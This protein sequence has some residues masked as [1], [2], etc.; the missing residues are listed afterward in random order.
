[1]SEKISDLAVEPTVPD[2]TNLTP[3]ETTEE[4][5]VQS[6]I[7][8]FTENKMYIYI[9][10]AV[11][12]LGVVLYY[13][14]IKNKKE[15]MAQTDKKPRLALPKSNN[16]G[17]GQPQTQTQTQPKASEVPGPFNPMGQE[18]YVLDNNGNPVKVSGN[19]PMVNQPLP[20]L[21]L[22]NQQ[23]SQ[24][25]IMMLQKQMMEKKMMEQQMMEQ[26][27][28]E[29]QMREAQ[30][31]AQAQAQAKKQ[32]QQKIKLEHPTNEEATHHSENDID[33]ELARIRANE[34]ENVAEHNLTHSELA[35]INKKLEMMNSNNQ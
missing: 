29:Q 17:S 18:Y 24:Q 7:K 31:Q 6:I 4:G 19:F 2:S 32:S 20:P 5:F 35:E 11:I 25:E 15:T 12:V 27:M 23:P 26:Q 9:G 8:K 16:D 14:F 10:I 21:P 22:P 13:F 30:L 3:A 28:M 1:M 34:D 33:I